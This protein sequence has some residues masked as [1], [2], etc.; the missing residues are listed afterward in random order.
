MSILKIVHDH[1]D[2]RGEVVW[3]MESMEGKGL[4]VNKHHFIGAYMLPDTLKCPQ[5]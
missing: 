2:L 3:E 4:K 1:E 5:A